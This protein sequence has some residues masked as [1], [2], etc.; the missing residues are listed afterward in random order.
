MKNEFNGEE[1]VFSTMILQHLDTCKRIKSLSQPM[2]K[3][4]LKQ[5]KD[6][7]VRAKAI[8]LLKENIGINIWDLGK[9]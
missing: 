9:I 7:N 6:L 4:Q 3:K 5:I 8:K 2:Y 1:I